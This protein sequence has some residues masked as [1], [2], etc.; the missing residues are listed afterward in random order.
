MSSSI[1]GAR[2]AAKR[3]ASDRLTRE[4]RA[5]FGVYLDEL[6]LHMLF[7]QDG[8]VLIDNF[9]PEKV[10]TVKMA[11]NILRFLGHFEEVLLL[12]NLCVLAV[13]LWEEQTESVTVMRSKTYGG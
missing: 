13:T 9:A 12:R 6:G 11:D 5:L 7:G 3:R 2:V 8:Q 1:K 10:V 4:E